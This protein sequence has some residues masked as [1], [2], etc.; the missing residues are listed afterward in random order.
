M[1]QHDYFLGIATS[2]KELAP[3]IKTFWLGAAASIHIDGWRVVSEVDGYAVSI[4][5]KG[6][7]APSPQ[8]LFFVNLGGYMAGKLEEQHNVVLTVQP[9][10]ASA[11]KKLNKLYFFEPIPRCQCSYR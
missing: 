11:I 8:K 4:V 2:P 3:D 7:V 9:D 5:P 10:R 6:N 1:E